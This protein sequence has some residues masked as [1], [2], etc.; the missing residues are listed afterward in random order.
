MHE[1]VSSL[2]DQDLSR[3]AR[4]RFAETV[5]RSADA[6]GF[7][8]RDLLTYS[9]SRFLEGWP[10]L[11]RLAEKTKKHPVIDLGAGDGLDAEV[12]DELGFAP[13]IGVDLR[14]KPSQNPRKRM[15]KGEA[16]QFLQAVPDEYGNVM[17]NGFLCADWHDVESPYLPRILREIHRVLPGGGVFIAVYFDFEYIAEKI[18]LRLNPDLSSTVKVFEKPQEAS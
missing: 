14:A 18:G 4:T 11:Q 9:H 7:L 1:H 2:S 12:I 8:P 6:I 3:Q 15:I 5:L 17:A 10:G 13:Y 16:L